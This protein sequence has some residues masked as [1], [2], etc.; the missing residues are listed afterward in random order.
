M[1]LVDH[2][3]TIRPHFRPVEVRVGVPPWRVGGARLP[4][5]WAVLLLSSNRAVS[6][7]RLIEAVWE[8]QPRAARS[9]VRTYVAELRWELT[10]LGARSSLVTESAGYRLRISPDELDVTRSL[11]RPNIASGRCAGPGPSTGLPP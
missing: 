1:T 3:R 6:C 4:A 9:N 10:D 5:L 2:L 7:E 8:G 11:R